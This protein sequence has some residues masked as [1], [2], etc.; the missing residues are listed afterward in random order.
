MK[1]LV[2]HLSNSIM[3]VLK[4]V[5]R[6]W[7]CGTSCLSLKH[8]DL[9]NLIMSI[10]TKGFF[11]LMTRSSYF[12]N[13]V[14]CF[15]SAPIDLACHHGHHDHL[16]HSLHNYNYKTCAWLWMILIT[17]K[18]SQQGRL[19][20]DIWGVSF[21]TAV[22]EPLDIPDLA[23]FNPLLADCAIYRG[24]RKAI[25]N[26]LR[27]KNRNVTISIHILARNRVYYWD[28]CL[29]NFTILCNLQIYLFNKKNYVCYV[30]DKEMLF[31]KPI[32]HFGDWKNTEYM[33]LD[34]TKQNALKIWRPWKD[35]RAKLVYL[36]QHW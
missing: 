31:R 3:F 9:L 1:A 28:I 17:I 15:D 11:H 13:T 6:K 14:D 26:H 25:F 19:A 33:Y 8:M 12:L 29:N 4:P 34:D 32:S 5:E 18:R 22:W 30:L 23:L 7:L 21:W 24:P 16:S 36:S 10:K 35:L 27:N 2:E 20:G